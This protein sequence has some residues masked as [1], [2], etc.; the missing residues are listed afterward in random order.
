MQV[1][2]LQHRLV[3]TPD[4]QANSAARAPSILP[5]HGSATT[6]ST[7]QKV[8]IESPRVLPWVSITVLCCIFGFMSWCFLVAGLYYICSKGGGFIGE[9]SKKFKYAGD[10]RSGNSILDLAVNCPASD[11]DCE[12][13]SLGC[14]LIAHY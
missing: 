10:D 9:S 11:L 1:P 6:G 14:K 2:A 12:R 3:L 5:H 4:D 13:T 7:I 8:I